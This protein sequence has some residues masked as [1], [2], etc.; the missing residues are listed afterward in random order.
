M[1]IPSTQ[2][3]LKPAQSRS[4]RPV[5]AVWLILTLPICLVVGAIVP[6]TMSSSQSSPSSSC[7]T[8]SF[9][10]NGVLQTQTINVTSDWTLAWTCDP[11]SFAFGSY[12]VQVFVYNLDGSLAWPS[13]RFV[14]VVTRVVQLRFIRAGASV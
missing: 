9:S 2:P 3:K 5:I 13:T 6:G 1:P 10:S 8:Y 4:K 11:S 14:A 7:S 12:N